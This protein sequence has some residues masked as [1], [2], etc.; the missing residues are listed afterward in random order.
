MNKFIKIFKRIA[1]AVNRRSRQ[2]KA[3]Y[4]KVY[5]RARSIVALPVTLSV[6]LAVLL[7]LMCLFALFFLAGCGQGIVTDENGGQAQP[8]SEQASSADEQII[9]DGSAVSKNAESSPDTNGPAGTESLSTEPLSSDTVLI[10]TDESD[11]GNTGSKTETANVS[12]GKEL[13]IL[14][15]PPAINLHIILGPEYAQ[16]NQ[17]CFYRVMADVSGEPFP[18]MSFSKDDSNGAWGPNIAQINLT[19]DESYTLRCEASNSQGATAAEIKLVWVDNPAGQQE[20]SNGE[21]LAPEIFVDYTDSANFLVDVNL[22]MQQVSV[23]YKETIIK[24]MP[25][26]G[27]KPETPTP[28]GVYTT[29]QKIYYAWI[30]KFA[31]GAF[32]WT[33]FYGPYL[34]HSVPYD[35]SGNMMAEELNKMGTPAS[36]GCV[37]LLLEDAKW[38]YETLPLGIK[39]SIHN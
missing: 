15:A 30:P 27:G 35:A 37:R 23:L 39:V 19:K 18:A 16:E 5:F 6:T 1:N 22:T 12:E 11:A 2:C 4:G 10:K 34:F 33:R 20:N 31:Q 29:N 32:Y 9:K 25:C 24:T 14:P 17:V 28:Q 13:K 3:P 36:H 8:Q 26:S 7:S 38:F 21:Q